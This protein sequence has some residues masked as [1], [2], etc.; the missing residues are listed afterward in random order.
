MVC[1]K[2][3][4]D[5]I[6]DK[7]D[8]L[9][10]YLE[11]EGENFHKIRAYRNAANIIRGIGDDIAEM[12]R[13]GDD[14]KVFSGIGKNIENK[15][16]EIVRTNDLEKLKKLRERYPQGILNILNISGLGIKKIKTLLKELDI[17]TLKQLLDYAREGK[18]RHL[19]GFG[20]KMEK[21]ILNFLKENIKES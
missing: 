7:L 15:I 2:I 8:E 17:R 5:E 9:A 13:H 10:I 18:I 21:K 6:A 16:I 20:E 3:T 14:L 11:L 12:V 4:N 19:P 1:K